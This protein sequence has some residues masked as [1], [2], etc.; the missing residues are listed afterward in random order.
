[1][2]N[3]RRVLSKHQILQN[4]WRYDFGGNSNVVETYVSYLRRKLNKLGPP[5]DPDRAAGGLHARARRGLMLPLSLRTRLV[6]G[7]I[8][9]AGDRP[10]RRGRRRRTRRCARSCCTG[11]TTRWT[12]SHPGVETAVFP[13]HSAGSRARPDIGGARLARRRLCRGPQLERRSSSVRVRPAVPARQRARRPGVP[14]IITLPRA[15]QRTS[16]GDRG[17]VPHGARRRTGDALSRTR[18]DRARLRRTTCCS[19]PRRCRAST[20]RCTACS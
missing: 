9:L 16:E 5:R 10:R 17:Q 20:A 8:V 4:V 14:K 6:L 11:S 2:L 7:V 12:A 3:P 13:A 18:V 15:G 19:S 1:M